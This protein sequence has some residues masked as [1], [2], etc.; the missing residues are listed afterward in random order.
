MA[1]NVCGNIGELQQ[2]LTS[3]IGNRW[4]KLKDVA[5]RRSDVRKPRI[6][7]VRPSSLWSNEFNL[8]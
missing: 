7:S 3:S 2:W 6:H 1:A 5:I 8:R 4:L